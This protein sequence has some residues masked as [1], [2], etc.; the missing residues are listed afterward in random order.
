M[1]RFTLAVVCGLLFPSVSAAQASSSCLTGDEGE[2]LVI[3]LKEWMT[4]TDT[5]DVRLRNT[6]FRIPLVDTIAVQLVTDARICASAAAAYPDTTADRPVYVVTL[7]REG[8][9]V[10]DPSD[11]AGEYRT[12]ILFDRHWKEIGGWTGP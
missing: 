4:V 12:V 8:Y 2:G 7:G 10:L 11:M 1:R 9:A 6:V 5:A 3:H